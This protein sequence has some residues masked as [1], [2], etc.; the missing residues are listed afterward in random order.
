MNRSPPEIRTLSRNARRNV[1]REAHL[2]LKHDK[3]FVMFLPTILCV[4]FSVAGLYVSGIR[5]FDIEGKD[6]FL[7]SS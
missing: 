1:T 5:L 6:H 4:L 7:E 2:L 3:P